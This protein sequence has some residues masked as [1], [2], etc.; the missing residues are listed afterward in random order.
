MCDSQ[1]KEVAVLENALT[2]EGEDIKA[3]TEDGQ[4]PSDIEKKH[5][6]DVYE[7]IAPHFSNTRYKPWPWVEQYLLALPKGS[8]NLDV[9]CGNGKYLEVNKDLYTVGTDRSFN[10]IGICWER[11][12]NTQAFVANSL[13]LNMRSNWFDSVISIAVIHHFSS[14]ELRIQAIRELKWVC[15]VG[16]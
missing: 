5:V 9:G 14:D 16:G 15:K 6:H 2:G 12:P 3:M 13:S 1:N 11:E 8:L 10:L 7:R 4:M